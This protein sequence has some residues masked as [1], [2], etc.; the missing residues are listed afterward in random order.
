[1]NMPDETKVQQALVNLSIE[2]WRFAKLFGRV[3]TKLDAGES[4]R[5]MNQLRYFLK[6]IDETLGTSDLKL[7]NLEGQLYDTGIAATALNVADFEPND[8]LVIDQMIEPIV[9]NS[10]GLVRSGT[11]LLRKA[12]R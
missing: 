2:S 9:M 4:S 10:V 3:L 1:M 7:V 6:G 11:V 5:Y 12:E 8:L